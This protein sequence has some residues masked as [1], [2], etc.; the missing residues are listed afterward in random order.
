MRLGLRQSLLL[1]TSLAV[2][3]GACANNEAETR[4]DELARAIHEQ[5]VEHFVRTFAVGLPARAMARAE[6]DAHAPTIRTLVE[7]GR[8]GFEPDPAVRELVTLLFAERDY[9]HLFVYGTRLTPDGRAVVETLRKAPAHGLDVDPMHLARAE[10]IIAALESAGDIEPIVRGLQLSAEDEAT[11]LA[12]MLDHTALDGTL[13]AAD[14]VFEMIVTPA[15]DNPL[16][17]VARGVADLTERLALGAESGPE[18]E[19]VLAAGFLRYA[20]ANRHANLGYVND[21]QARDS[22]WNTEDPAQ[23]E[24]I[25]RALAGASFR[26][27]V[28]Q[29]FGPVAAELQ[30]PF[31]QYRRLLAGA[32]EYRGYVEAGGWE[33]LDVE[34]LRVGDSGPDV[35]ALRRRLAAERYFDGPMDDPR[36]DRALAEAVVG[37]QR[38][39]QLNEDG[40]VSGATLSSLNVPAE[41]RYAQIM[42]ALDFWR[43]TRRAHHWDAE[44][45][46]VNVPDFHAELFEGDVSVYR[47]RVVVGRSL[48]RRNPDGTIRGETPLF[49]DQMEYIVFN[50]YW[51]VPDSIREEEYDHLIAADPMWLENEGFEL[52]Y[53]NGREWLRQLPGE[54][55]ALGRVK[56]LFPNLHD[57]Y[58]H[59]TPSRSLFA[60]PTR[61]FS[62]GCVRV[63]N[64]LDLARLLLARDR[65]WSEDRTR[66]YVQQQLDAGTE[67]WV[68]LV[69]PIPIHIEYVSVRGGDDGRV[70]F[71]ADPYR[72]DRPHVDAWQQ[73]LFGTAT[74]DP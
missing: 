36:F 49:S 67:Q 65:E 35:L 72:H 8:L 55:N 15:A 70:E 14:A 25:V 12:F 73:R 54:R 45:I 20:I 16:P 47:W 53:E 50:P 56:F 40:E 27:G 22:G 18:L 51:N 62:H 5:Q 63:Q 21:A 52:A 57:V 19:L 2:S 34:S 43:T 3:A 24:E 71:L 32:E 48:G 11:L 31:E 68:G 9:E 4:A 41:R 66:R 23:R 17:R 61:A 13:P 26:R 42:A 28:E 69:T 74:P 1:L 29:G 30:P 44:H 33:L 6:R 58:M 7:G 37:Y 60:R 39:H 10:E 59:D 46:W 64:P 38:S